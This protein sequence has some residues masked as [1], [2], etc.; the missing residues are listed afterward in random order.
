MHNIRAATAAAL[1]FSAALGVMGC[2]GNAVGALPKPGPEPAPLTG[3]TKPR[4][5]APDF[6]ANAQWLNTDKPLTLKDLRG[7][8]VVLDFWTFG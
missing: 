3:Q 8:V 2:K 1:L 7:K 6:P 5:K 4:Q